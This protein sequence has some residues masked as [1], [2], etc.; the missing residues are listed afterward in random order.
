MGAMCTVLREDPATT[1]R[2]Q[3]TTGRTAPTNRGYR[4]KR[5]SGVLEI[6]LRH[7]R[8]VTFHGGGAEHMTLTL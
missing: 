8:V 4:E 1:E 2:E 3:P 6:T 5:A 7:C